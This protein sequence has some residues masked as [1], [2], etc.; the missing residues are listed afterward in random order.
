MVLS[1]IP[2]GTDMDTLDDWVRN[3]YDLFGIPGEDGSPDW[4]EAVNTHGEFNELCI[5]TTPARLFIRGATAKGEEMEG[6]LLDGYELL[7][8]GDPDVDH[9]IQFAEGSDSNE[10]LTDEYF[11][12]YLTD[13]TVNVDDL[14]A[15]YDDRGVPTPFLEYL[16]AA[17]EGSNP[18]VY[19]KGDPE[20]DFGL[21]LVDAAKHD[22]ASVDVDMTVPDNFPEGTYT[23]QGMI[24]DEAGNETT[25]T[26]KLIVIR[27]FTI[28]LPLIIK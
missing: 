12:L 24:K 26:L 10:P 25:V 2:N 15:Y 3:D 21:S 6:S 22:L 8:T 27:G 17:A 14:K 18:F 13:S 23:V 11:G 28:Y 4:N 9:L 7:T 1:E 20:F 16:K 19:I 5:D